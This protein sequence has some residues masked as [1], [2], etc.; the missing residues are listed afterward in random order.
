MWV[1]LDPGNAFNGSQS[2]SF[3][4]EQNVEISIRVQYYLCQIT[5]AVVQYQYM[6]AF[7]YAVNHCHFTRRQIHC[8]IVVIISRRRQK[9]GDDGLRSWAYEHWRINEQMEM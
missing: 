3:S 7:R 2:R 8:L 5:L 1:N 4:V 6:P 9:S